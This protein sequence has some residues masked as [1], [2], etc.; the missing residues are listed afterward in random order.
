MNEWERH[1]REKALILENNAKAEEWMRRNYGIVKR[2]LGN[3][4]TGQD[5]IA[6]WKSQ[7][8]S[9]PPVR[10][11]SD[12]IHW[13][14]D[15]DT[16]RAHLAGL[17]DAGYITFDDI[18]AVLDG[19]EIPRTAKEPEDRTILYIFA[20]WWK[21][22]CIDKSFFSSDGRD[23]KGI[24]YDE[25]IKGSFTHRSGKPFNNLSKAA[26]PDK[27]RKGFAR[28]GDTLEPLDKELHSALSSILK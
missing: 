2:E 18:E 17:Y 6:L 25:F 12:K 24:Q 1:K 10:A 3:S 20:V 27:E 13:K 4:W 5:L 8:V 21:L 26:R 7:T 14:A 16:L 22:G 9:P 28:K 23:T 15:P 11:L 19:T